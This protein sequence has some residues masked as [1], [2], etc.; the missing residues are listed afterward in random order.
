TALTLLSLYLEH[1]KDDEQVF[2]ELKPQAALSPASAKYPPSLFNLLR[3]TLGKDAADSIKVRERADSVEIKDKDLLLSAIK[4]YPSFYEG[5]DRIAW[6]VTDMRDKKEKAI[7][8]LQRMYKEYPPFRYSIENKETALIIR[9]KKG[10][11]KSI[12]EETEAEAE[13]SKSWIL[14]I[15]GQENLVSKTMTQDFNSPELYLLH[16]IQARWM[17]KYRQLQEK[18]TP[19]NNRQTQ[20][21][22]HQLNLGIQMSILAISEAL[23]FGG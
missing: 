8:V 10:E 13:L 20:T 9:N 4:L 17:S 6:L 21:Q 12:L 19:A 14:K 18:K 3:K 7:D 1:S 23:G 16:K 11:L 22:L 15:N 2:N 5:V